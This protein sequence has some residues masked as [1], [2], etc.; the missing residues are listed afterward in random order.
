MVI[1]LVCT[2]V[3]LKRAKWAFINYVSVPREGGH[4]K[5]STYSYFGEGDIKLILT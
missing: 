3:S 4:G 2:D 1:I 5:I